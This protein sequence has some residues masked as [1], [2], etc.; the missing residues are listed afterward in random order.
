MGEIQ[1]RKCIVSVGVKE[2]KEMRL[3][4]DSIPSIC[5]RESILLVLAEIKA[6]VITSPD[7]KK[8]Q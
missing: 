7:A 2:I 4:I 6:W 1:I 5:C 3:K 8:L